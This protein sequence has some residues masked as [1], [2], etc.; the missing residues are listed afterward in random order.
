ML[1]LRAW[2]NPQVAN[3]DLCVRGTPPPPRVWRWRSNTNFYHQCS[4]ILTTTR[5]VRQTVTCGCYDWCQRLVQPRPMQINN[6][7]HGD[8]SVDV[9]NSALCHLLLGSH[10]W[11][12]S[13]NEICLL[14]LP[15]S[16]NHRI[17]RSKL[18]KLQNPNKDASTV[19]TCKVFVWRQLALRSSWRLHQ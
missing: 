16:T 17:T 4:V 18:S 6:N 2:S 10:T 15:N 19:D 5:H 8:E 3:N 14:Q 9:Q 13:L 11:K 7:W 12:W 1:F